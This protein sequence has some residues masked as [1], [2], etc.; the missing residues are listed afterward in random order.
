MIS[1][2]IL[3]PESCTPNSMIVK[4]ESMAVW[5]NNFLMKIVKNEQGTILRCLDST[6]KVISQY[7]N[8]DT[9]STDGT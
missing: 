5:M 8:I 9:G 4:L 3:T 7:V 6:S 1:K 2:L